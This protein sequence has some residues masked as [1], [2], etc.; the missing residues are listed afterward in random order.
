[1]MKQIQ[2]AGGPSRTVSYE[3]A[4]ATFSA[5]P[6]AHPIAYRDVPWPLPESSIGDV[7]LLRRTILQGASGPSDVRA[8]LRAEMLR[9]HPDKFGA[10]FRA[11]LVPGDAAR[12]L[13]G[14]KAVSQQLTAILTGQRGGGA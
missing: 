8:R 12:I 2:E 9:W 3:S 5:L 6:P 7:A 4:W 1:M 10:R 11:R 13:A 14:V